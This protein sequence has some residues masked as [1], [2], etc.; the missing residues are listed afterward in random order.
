MEKADYKFRISDFIPIGGIFDYR[1]RNESPDFGE[2]NTDTCFL[3]RDLILLGYNTSLFLATSALAVLVVFRGL[4]SV[5][6]LSF[7]MLK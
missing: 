1:K 2:G 6:Q 3:G 7:T 4:E 5:I